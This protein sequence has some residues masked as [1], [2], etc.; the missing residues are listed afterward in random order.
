M[1]DTRRGRCASFRDGSRSKSSRRAK[2]EEIVALEGRRNMTE[3][4]RLHDDVRLDEE[5]KH[6]LDAKAAQKANQFGFMQKYHH[7]GGY[8]QDKKQDGTEEIY[9]RNQN[10]A[11]DSEK[12]DKE[13]LPSAL[14]KRRNPDGKTIG[15]TKHK[16]LKE[17]DTTDY[18]SNWANADPER[19]AKHEKWLA[20]QAEK[21]VK[22][23]EM[24][25]EMMRM[26]QR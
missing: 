1:S 8:F 21:K 3:E 10:V 16:S 13:L 25:T 9:L 15:Q 22:L 12:F 14:H 20:I 18:T 19:R 26:G 23:E 17:S 5:Y 4:E 11:L 6:V 7:S 2:F 24:R